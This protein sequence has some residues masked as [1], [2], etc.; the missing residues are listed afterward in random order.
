MNESF[1]RL[2]G[3]NGPKQIQLSSGPYS[4]IDY[5]KNDRW[6]IRI[7]IWSELSS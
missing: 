4:V 6:L 1:L 5:D 7:R 2:S 3:S